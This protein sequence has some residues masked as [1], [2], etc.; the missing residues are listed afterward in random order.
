MTSARQPGLQ[1]GPYVLLEPLGAGGMGEVWKARDTRLGREV[2][3]K[4]AHAELSRGFEREARAIAALNHPHIATLYD[5]GPDYLVMELVD[6]EPLAG[7]LPAV[8]TLHVARQMAAAL[9]AAHAKG[10]VHRDLKPANVLVTT[11]GVKLLDFGLARWTEPATAAD[12]AAPTLEATS[13]GLI[14]GTPQF[15]SPEQARGE[16]VG[17]A[18]D[19]FSLGAVLYFCLSGKAPF[20]GASPV[21]TLMQVI[22]GEPDPLPAGSPDLR[23]VVKRLLAKDPAGRF[24]SASQLRQALD[25]I[26]TQ[27]AADEPTV[28]LPAPTVPRRRFPMRAAA[29]GVAVLAA[30]FFIWH[31]IGAR[32]HVPSPEARRWFDEGANA[33]RDGTFLKASQTLERAVALDPKFTLARLR[34]AE[35]H[36]ELDSTD[37]AREVL[38]GGN[39]S[40]DSL[41]QSE[42]LLLEAV[43]STL[44]GEYATALARHRQLVELAPTEDKAAALVDLGRACEKAEKPLDAIANYREAARIS[45]RFAAAF[46]RLG[47]LLARRQDRAGAEAAFAQA[48]THY[49]QLSATEGQIEVL[50]QR[51]AMLNRAGDMDSAEQLL[52]QALDLAR[53]AQAPHQQIVL[54][55]QRSIIAARRGVLDQAERLAGQALDLARR[56]QLEALVARGLID[57][58][59]AHFLGNHPAPAEDYFKQALDYA[60]RWKNRRAEARARLSLGSLQIQNGRPAEGAPNVEAAL[61]YYQRS[62]SRTETMQA[63]I[64]LGRAARDQGD[65]PR[66]ESLFRQQLDVARKVGLAESAANALHGLGSLAL[67]REHYGKA[68]EWFNQELATLGAGATPTQRAYALMGAAQAHMLLGQ[69]AEARRRQQ[70]ALAAVAKL[71]T[72]EALARLHA[73]Q[74]VQMVLLERRP[75]GLASALT[76]AAA[77]DPDRANAACLAAGL[78]RNRAAVRQQCAAAAPVFAS[79]GYL[80]AG[81]EEAAER[82]ALAALEAANRHDLKETAFRASLVLARVRSTDPLRRNAARGAWEALRKSWP[83]PDVESYSA[84]PD[85]RQRLAVLQKL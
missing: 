10:I 39:L 18:S 29:V 32:P 26:D 35:A 58:G 70:E 68:L 4:F 74:Q 33:L 79:E 36:A 71:G 22:Q 77:A 57:L 37:R 69:F 83:A 20:R 80:E 16:A 56:A 49:R 54:L 9:E 17:P 6:G 1:L 64:L 28:V 41:P 3:I 38:L 46:L 65:F 62:E 23:P 48:E 85:V 24:A 34:L 19:L 31:A 25:A 61:N 50:Y 81:D 76:S 72:A 60:R 27:A 75:A 13:P 45:P 7:A 63:L 59:N 21:E 5:I 44:T 14:S 30:A 55:L 2:A 73:T 15:M 11:H 67:R 53:N 47:V 82:A 8:E 51:A 52:T 42:R 84:R 66:A 43:S 12:A 78:L 40:P